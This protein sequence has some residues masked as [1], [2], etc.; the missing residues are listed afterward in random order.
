[1]SLLDIS[2]FIAT[3]MPNWPGDTPTEFKQVASIAGGYSANVGRLTM[4]VHSGSHTDAPYH[5]SDTGAKID[6]VPLDTYVGPAVVVDV[7]GHATLTPDLFAAIDLGAT[8]RVLFKTN[9]W[10]DA[11]VFPPTWPVI[12]L[13]L[14]GWL[15]ARGVK[16]IGLDF[17]SVDER[18]SKDLP[19]HHAC[20]AAGL[21]I[22]ENLNLREAAP[23]VYDLIALPLKIRGG[24]GS[25]VRAALRARS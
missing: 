20:L 21:I 22:L 16:L 19:V 15:A 12:D 6:E 1:M 10:P 11:A 14:P 23:G 8:P 25:P 5:Y 7:I 24:D 2:R 13:A 3:G 18:H 4:S 17:P 9:S